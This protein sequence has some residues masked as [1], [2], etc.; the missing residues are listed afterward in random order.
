MDRRNSRD[1]RHLFH[2]MKPKRLKTFADREILRPTWTHWIRDVHGM[3]RGTSTCLEPMLWNPDEGKPG[4]PCLIL[5]R[6]AF[7]FDFHLIDSGNTYH[8]TRR[9]KQAIKAG[10]D[11][12]PILRD[13]AKSITRSFGQPDEMFITTP[14]PWKAVVAIGYEEERTSA[15]TIEL[16]NDVASSSGLPLID[17][18]GWVVSSPGFAETDTII[19]D[20]TMSRKLT[21]HF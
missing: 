6:E 7:D 5:D 12:A 8:L 3:V 4:E 15:E 9:L 11:I 16:I 10:E 13:D 20:A 18:S 19:L 14:I 2:W 17:M 1:N 21:R